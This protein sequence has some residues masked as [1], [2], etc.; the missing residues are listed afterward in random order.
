MARANRK[1]VLTCAVTGA[2]HTP[3][4]SKYLPLTPDEIRDDAIAAAEAGA[5]VLHLHARNPETGAPSS[6]PAVF[7]Q[8]LPA[9][10]EATDAVINITLAGGD[11]TLEEVVVVGYSQQTRGDI[12]GSV[13]SVDMEEALKVPVVNAAEALQGRVTGVQVVS[14]GSPGAAPNVNIR[15]IGSTNGTGPLYIIDGVQTTDAN[16]LTSINP[17][18]IDQ[19][20]VLKDGAAAIYG[21]RA[22]NGVIIVTTKSG[23]YSMQ[24]STVTVDIYT[25]MSSAVGLPSML[26]VQQ[27]AD[28]LW[29]GY[30]NDFAEVANEPDAEFRGHVQ[31]GRDPNGPVIPTQLNLDGSKGE[32]LDAL[33]RPGGTNWWNEITQSAP[34]VSATV[35]MAGGTET[36]KSFM[37]LNYL[38]RGG[39]VKH[40]GFV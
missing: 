35:S 11:N 4:M 1:I 37:S 15:G 24:K 21:S 28:M 6:D 33:V 20:N 40:T 3:T 9:I 10:H 29:E 19:M 16:L 36:S 2:I 13:A 17:S 22:S 14:N 32:G 25:G 7:K 27:H 26:N 23:S 38:N 12:T 30:T 39:V 5:S 34:T 8:F 31:Y 18:D